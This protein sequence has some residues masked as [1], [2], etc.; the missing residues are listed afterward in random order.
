MVKK[1]LGKKLSW[2]GVQLFSAVLSMYCVL[3]WVM[4]YKH[5]QALDTYWCGS[6]SF[7]SSLFFSLICLSLFL[8]N[9]PSKRQEYFKKLFRGLLTIV[10]LA[11][12][13]QLASNFLGYENIILSSIE[14]KQSELVSTRLWFS[15]ISSIMFLLYVLG[16]AIRGLIPKDKPALMYLAGVPH[17]LSVFISVVVIYG[18]IADVPMFTNLREKSMSI[19]SALLFILINIS[20][21]WGLGSIALC[22]LLGLPYNENGASTYKK[23]VFILP[24]LFMSLIMVTSFALAVY[25]RL[26][27]VNFKNQIKYQ[28]SSN[29]DSKTSQVS[30]FIEERLNYGRAIEEDDFLNENAISLIDGKANAYNI[31]YLQKRAKGI[32]ANFGFES[33]NLVSPMGDIIVSTSDKASISDIETNKEFK[34]VLNNKKIHLG[35]IFTPISPQ[36]IRLENSRL[37]L[38]VPIV[39]ENNS[40]SLI[41]GV[42]LIV[43][44]PMKTLYPM[45]RNWSS[46]YKTAETTMY[47]QDGNDLL[48]LSTLQHQTNSAEHYRIP[49]ES[50]PGFISVKSM[51]LQNQIIEGVDYSGQLVMGIGREIPVTKWFIMNKIDLKEVN[52]PFRT[53]ARLSGLILLV[54]IASAS[55]I[56]EMNFRRKIAEENSRASSEW[57]A[58]FDSIEDVLLLINSRN[59]IV[60]ANKSI[61]KVLGLKQQDVYEKNVE[62]LLVNIAGN[63]GSFLS[64][65]A[66]NLQRISIKTD[67]KG[68]WLNISADPVFNSKA[69]LEGFVMLI[70]DVTVTYEAENTTRINEAKFRSIFNHSPIGK[71]L[72]TPGGML[73][74]N[75]AFALMLGYSKEELVRNWQTISHPDDISATQAYVEKIIDGS[76]Q[77]ARFKKR[78]LHKNGNTIWA[79]VSSYLQRDNDGNPE[80]FITSVLDITKEVNYQKQLD[81]T[82]Q[83][84]ESLI[85]YASAPIIVWDQDYHIS[86]YNP[87]FA[88]LTGISCEEAIGRNV[89]DL[90]PPDKVPQYM[91]LIHQTTYGSQWSVVEIEIIH[92]NGKISTLLWNSAFVYDS[93]GENPVAIIAQGQDITE[94]LLVEKEIKSLNESLEKRVIERTNQLEASNKELEAFSYSVSHDLRAPLRHISGYIELLDKYFR[95]ELTEKGVHYLDEIYDSAIQMGKLIDDLLSFSRTNKAE[96]KFSHVNMKEV[97]E[98]V[99]ASLSHDWSERHIHWEIAELPDT[100]GDESMIT[101]VW[102]NL[103]LNAVKF[104]MGRDLA[105]INIGYTEEHDRY[106]YYIKD[107]GA[108]FDMQYAG[109]LFGVFQRL[110][111]TTDFAGTGIGLA[112]VRKIITKHGGETWAYA[113]P[114]NGATFYFSLLKQRLS[115]AQR[116]GV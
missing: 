82:N 16:Y 9:F 109:K 36:G 34:T 47:S 14:T 86:K 84:L 106:V 46:L 85:K 76:I 91:Q 73:N 35:E 75:D 42:W 10:A 17:L 30:R 83:Y 20:A 22:K 6:I 74:V 48:F 41:K 52:A 89:A 29:L 90:F 33:V 56:I 70:S 57:Q 63:C 27:F 94:R 65:I 39:Y 2:Y 100:L 116:E 68:K 7:V 11:S 77:I 1:D 58:T 98:A 53:K 105:F 60:R 4:R 3:A 87:A 37:Y 5:A 8:V 110:H 79:D 99:I 96:V 24:V 13:Y 88:K 102:T 18:Y 104:T 32:C 93:E 21:L 112:N 31:E 114:D 40:V 101:L 23:N 115:E 67:F 69:E 51:Q 95:A 64:D 108:G 55:I 61:E 28:L 66:T 15:N 103:I 54:L 38:W 107:N 45:I 19:W 80:Y 25:L 59:Q 49:I 81:E 50:N 92:T 43:I 111:A 113:E 78:Y 12:M 62:K 44:D 71:S 72:T 97:V 26:E